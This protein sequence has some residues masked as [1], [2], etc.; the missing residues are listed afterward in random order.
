MKTAQV[1]LRNGAA[2]SALTLALFAAAA[3]SC[4]HLA[5]VADAGAQVAAGTGVIDRNTA[6]AISKTGRAVA[7]AAE[8]ITP[9]QEYYLGRAVGATI[10]TTYKIWTGSPELTA[11]LNRIC[12]A[13]VINSDKPEIYN[14]YHVALLDSSEINACA[15]SGGHIFVT[16]GLVACAASEDALAG[17]IA[18]EIAHIHLRHSVKAI[19]NSR[20]NQALLVTGA[21][22]AGIAGGQAGYDL[23]ELVDVFNETVGEAVTTLVE[24]GYSQQQEFD[25][26]AKALELLAGAGYNPSGLL[27][28]LKALEKNQGRQPGGFTRTHPSPAR[29]VSSAQ[30]LMGIY[31]VEDT[32]SYRKTRY[33]SLAR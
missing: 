27:D 3:F 25:A 10:L 15:T 20:F 16:R 4:Q 28:M 32:G 23:W 12:A 30:K 14:G 2:V 6:D 31:R 19:K 21:S 1:F 17:V 33:N 22:A 7:S 11:Y 24:K 29:R 18:H 13:I 9:E 5:A 26:D 8:E